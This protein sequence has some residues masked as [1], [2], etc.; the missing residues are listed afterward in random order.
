MTESEEHVNYFAIGSMMNPKSMSLRGLRPVSSKPAILI[1]S[2]VVFKG[3]GGMA[4]CESAVGEEADGVLHEMTQEDMIKLDGIEVT[5]DRCQATCRLYDDSIVPCTVYMQSQKSG[6]AKLMVEDKLPGERYIDIIVR[7]MRAVGVR[8]EA[9]ENML[10]QPVEPRKKAEDFLK[11]AVPEGTP[12]W[13][14]EQLTAAAEDDK[15]VRCI[16][17]K[18]LEYDGPRDVPF[19]K[20]LKEQSGTDVTFMTACYLYEPS[21]GDPTCLEEM[22]A[23]HRAWVEDLV[24]GYSKAMG[25]ADNVVGLI[26]YPPPNPS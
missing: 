22:S 11:L 13:T 4:F 5:Y 17:G 21:Y 18:V 15:V 19:F 16:N 6:T 14:M 10:A 25:A 23:E 12:T 24:V 26:D 3:A 2:R 7:G 9:I 1:D 8:Q 20:M